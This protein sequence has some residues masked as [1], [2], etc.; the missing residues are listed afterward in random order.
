MV[1]TNAPSSFIPQDT[2]VPYATRRRESGGLNELILLCAIVLL[3]ASIALGAGVFVYQQYLTQESASKLAQIERAKES[4]DPS[5][6]HEL[7]RLDDRMKA[8]EKILS[9][10]S[11]PTAFFIALQQATLKT[12]AFR[13]L[14][15]EVPDTL[16]VSIH[17]AGVAQ[18]VNSIALQ[19]DIFSKSGIITSP[20]FSNIARDKDGVHFDLQALV[21]PSFLNYASLVSGVPGAAP[22]NTQAVPGAVEQSPFGASTNTVP[23]N[24]PPAVPPQQTP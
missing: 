10:H 21:N 2:G 23:A 22:A 18:S 9:A 14:R 11:A 24:N 1:E 15:F 16:R 5:L 17:M 12:V 7:T 4:F 6:I 19:A 20:I 13:T 3:I 8:S